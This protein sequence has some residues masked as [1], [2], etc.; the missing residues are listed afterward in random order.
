MSSAVVYGPPQATALRNT[1]MRS[2][3][4]SSQVI[5]ASLLYPGFGMID[6]QCFAMIAA[7]GM[8]L[9]RPLRER[10]FRPSSLAPAPIRRAGTHLSL[11]TPVCQAELRHL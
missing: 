2:F 5:E 1:N 9:D 10:S 6:V 4:L 8:A 3:I 11:G 7:V